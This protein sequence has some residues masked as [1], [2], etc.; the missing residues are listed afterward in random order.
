MQAFLD[1]VKAKLQQ[2]SAPTLVQDR[3][4]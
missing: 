3:A 4:G 2:T 1:V